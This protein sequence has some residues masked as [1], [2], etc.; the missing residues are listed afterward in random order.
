MSVHPSLEDDGH[1]RGEPHCVTLH[2]VSWED[3]ERLLVMRGDHSAPRIHY[4]DGEVE[5]MSPS[6][7]HES[8][9]SRIG[10]LL[11]AWCLFVG[12]DFEVVGAWTLKKE[13]KKAGAEPDECYIFRGEDME[14]PHLAI[15]VD[16]SSRTLDKLEICRRLK[17]AELWVW[18]RGHV[19][20]HVLRGGSYE[21]SER[22]EALPELDLPFLMQ[23]IDRK[24]TSQ[25]I[26]DYRAAL[27]A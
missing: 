14:R 9:K 7:T 4:L 24:T 2:G 8:V 23:F 27:G 10:C 16:W 5:I 12:I 18:Y 3:Y 19:Q 17:V 25:A 26:R 20:I 6:R 21:P 22:S 1:L 13:K 15:E 11:E